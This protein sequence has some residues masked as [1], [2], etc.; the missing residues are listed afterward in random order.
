MIMSGDLPVGSRDRYPLPSMAE[1]GQ[2]TKTAGSAGG[3]PGRPGRRAPA[4]SGRPAFDH[5]PCRSACLPLRPGGILEW[6]RPQITLCNH[7][8]SRGARAVPPICAAIRTI[9][10]AMLAARNWV[11]CAPLW[12]GNSDRLVRSLL[13]RRVRAAVGRR[14]ARSLNVAGPCAG[15]RT[16]LNGPVPIAN[17]LACPLRLRARPR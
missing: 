15:L 12:V 17:W 5:E 1:S 13:F 16:L 11:F 2:Q 14:V 7:P 4:T 8:P 10:I 6:H 3:Q 9:P